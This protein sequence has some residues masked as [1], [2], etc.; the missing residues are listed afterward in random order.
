MQYKTQWGQR[1]KDHCSMRSTSYTA[2]SITEVPAFMYHH[3]CQAEHLNGC[4]TKDSELVALKLGDTILTL[5][6]FINPDVD[7]T[8]I[9]GC[10]TQS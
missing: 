10:P 7:P 4:H 8:M 6:F 3:E 2:T 1:R 5:S 9:V